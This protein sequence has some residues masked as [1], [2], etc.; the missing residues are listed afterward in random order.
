MSARNMA[1]EKGIKR[2][3]AG[4]TVQGLAAGALSALSAIQPP[5][6]AKLHFKMHTSIRKS[7]SAIATSRE[8]LRQHVGHLTMFPNIT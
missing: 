4:A 3:E 7:L 1:L 8:T 2:C 6:G 5:A